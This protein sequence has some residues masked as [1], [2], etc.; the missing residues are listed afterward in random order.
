MRIVAIGCPGVH[1]ELHPVVEC[2]HPAAQLLVRSGLSQQE[3][4]STLADTQHKAG[5]PAV[6]DLVSLQVVVNSL[7]QGSGVRAD[8]LSWRRAGGRR[9]EDT[10]S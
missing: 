7:S 5:E 3:G 1:P 2:L 8:W 6:L 4:E 10:S 9:Q